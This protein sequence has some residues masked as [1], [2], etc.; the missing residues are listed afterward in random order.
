[1]RNCRSAVQKWLEVMASRPSA[2]PALHRQAPTPSASAMVLQAPGA[3]QG[4]AQRPG[5]IARSR[6]LGLQVSGQQEAHILFGGVGFFQ[7]E[8]RRL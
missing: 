4:Q 5:R 1:M 7:A 6:A 2:I 8:P 3:P